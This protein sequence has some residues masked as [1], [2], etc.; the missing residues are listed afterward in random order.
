M[1]CKASAARNT[2]RWRL[3]GM[4]ELFPRTIQRSLHSSS[5]TACSYNST[6]AA[7]SRFRCMR[8]I[9][10]WVGSGPAVASRRPGL[11]GSIAFRALRSFP[12]STF[13]L[14]CL[15]IRGMSPNRSGSSHCSA[16]SD[17]GKRSRMPTQAYLS[18]TLALARASLAARDPLQS[19]CIPHVKSIITWAS[20][21]QTVG[22][23]HIEG[24]CGMAAAAT[25]PPRALL[26]SAR[27]QKA[28][29]E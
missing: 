15:H 14:A 23:S 10:C 28:K 7:V 4:V 6:S 11:P 1:A 18:R 8:S 24:G 13:S 19:G 25:V 22:L 16:T 20:G 26:G 2:A 9:V 21:R 12:G 29:L 27:S 3:W 17:S 5:S